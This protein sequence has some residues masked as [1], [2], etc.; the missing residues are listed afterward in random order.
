MY[1]FGIGL[2]ID[3]FHIFLDLCSSNQGSRFIDLWILDIPAQERY[4]RLMIIILILFIGFLIGMM[5]E[6]FQKVNLELLKRNQQ[7]EEA[8]TQVKSLQGII[9]ICAKCKK[10]RDD[11][12]SYHNLEEYISQNSDATF[13]HGICPDCAKHIFL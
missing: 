4:I 13:T 12:G 6:R 2:V 10:I 11:K 1:G 7:L 9:P 8:M 3:L 5:I